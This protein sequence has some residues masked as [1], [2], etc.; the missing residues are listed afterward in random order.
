MKKTLSL[1]LAALLLAGML[2]ACGSVSRSD[3]EN[4]MSMDSME[5]EMEEQLAAPGEA[6]YGT[7]SDASISG[8]SGARLSHQKLIKTVE[9]QAETEDLDTVLAQLTE[10]ISSLGGYTEY[11]NVYNGS[12]YSYRR[13]RSA[14]LTIRIP[15]DKLNSLVAQV[16]GTSNV[17][18]KTERVDDVT[19]EYVDTQSRMEALQAEHD[20]LVELMDKAETMADLLEIEERLTEVRYELESVTSQ[21]RVLENLVSYATIE[22][23]IEEVEVLTEVEE[24]GVGQ[25]ISTGFMD[26][27]KNLGDRLVDLFVWVVTYSPQLLI[28][29]GVIVVIVWLL[30]RAA[31]KRAAKYNPPPASET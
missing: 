28:F 31:R 17:I 11:Q 22:L 15:T 18:S 13:Y 8:G 14:E 4:G 20:R 9:I 1:L 19:L 16:E 24:P 7:T 30:R 25:R 2:A 12:A 21:L 27:L 3:T 29:A 23:Y 10:Q 6:I 26:N 5:V